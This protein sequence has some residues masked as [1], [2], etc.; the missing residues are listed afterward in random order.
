MGVYEYEICSIQLDLASERR[1]VE[2]FLALQQ[3]KLDPDVDF[4][5]AV[6]SGGKLVGTGSLAGNVLKCIAVDP[7]YQGEALTNKIVTE[8]ELEAYHRDID[9]LFLFTRASNRAVFE[10]LGFGPVASASFLALGSEPDGADERAGGA[11][12]TA[13]VVLLEKPEGLIDTWLKQLAARAAA[14]PA[15]ALVM[16]CNPFTLG[17]RY[18]VE[19]ASRRAAAE[20]QRVH[21]FVVSAE[22]SLF[23]QQVRYELVRK[24]TAEF[25]N[26]RV[27]HGGPYIISGA[28]FP[29][30]FLR[31]SAAV[32]AAHARLDLRIFGERIAPALDIRRRMVGE[33]PYCPVTAAYNREMRRILPA[34]G[35]EVEEIPRL[36]HGGA[37]VSASKVRELIRENR[38]SEIEALVPPS[39]WEYLNRPEAVPVLERIRRENRRH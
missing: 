18:L 11:E 25:E 6:K 37:A 22:R 33:E 9:H 30:Y 35:I 26:V 10:S 13:E 23:P 15:T 8:L 16:N 14:G 38:W 4:T 34:F 28:T 2:E 36:S 5:L 12:A 3:L 27:H 21:L 19:K 39:T 17:H 20:G 7:E 1:L 29:S 31:D 24:G 32:T